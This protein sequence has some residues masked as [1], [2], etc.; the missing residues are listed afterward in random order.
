MHFSSEINQLRLQ[1]NLKLNLIVVE[2]IAKIKKTG[3][4][5]L[6]LSAISFQ[7]I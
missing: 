1:F 3:D 4:I 7:I 6:D 2:K 5:L